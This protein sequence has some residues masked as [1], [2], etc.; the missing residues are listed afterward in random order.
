MA[1]EKIEV[2]ISFAGSEKAARQMEALAGNTEDFSRSLANLS[3]EEV[4]AADKMARAE[5]QAKRL[6]SQVTNNT[7]GLQ[8]LVLAL[9]AQ[10]AEADRAATAEANLAREM[11]ILSERADI[12]VQ[13]FERQELGMH[14]VEAA[15]TSMA[16]KLGAATA[17]LGGMIS[18][19]GAGNPEMARLGGLMSVVGSAASQFQG[20]IDPLSAGIAALTVVVSAIAVAM[21]H[22]SERERALMETNN[23][24]S[25]SYSELHDEMA[26]ALQA[27]S[28]LERDMQ[29]LGTE[30]QA[31]ARVARLESLQ[32]TTV[33]ELDRLTSR[34]EEMNGLERTFGGAELERLDRDIAR[35]QNTLANLRVGI[36]GARAGIQA[37]RDTQA[38]EALDAVDPAMEEAPARRRGGGGRAAEDRNQAEIDRINRLNAAEE[39]RLAFIRQREEEEKAGLEEIIRLERQRA[40]EELQNM[41]AAKAAREAYEAE[42]AQRRQAQREAEAGAIRKLAAEEEARIARMRAQIDDQ[43]K[44]IAGVFST[45]FGLAIRGQE[46]LQSTA[47][48]LLRAAHEEGGRGRLRWLGRSLQSRWPRLREPPGRRCQS[49]GGCRAH[50][51][52]RIRGRDRCCDCPVYSRRRA[53]P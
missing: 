40:A 22:L 37:A 28:E 18:V 41:E 42:A 11:T 7:R 43:G 31:R 51:L 26:S 52:G 21:D 38:L 20:K 27:Q 47:S 39:Q 9:R 13:S 5:A 8:Q 12:A 29:G 34:R 30:T 23:A 2:E 36:E 16:S 15:S 1:D 14:A 53:T 50:R 45:A 35:E 44:E 49:R 48:G 25:R 33:A 32:A 10:R 24:L 46:D 17:S 4:A 3:R 6:E 19:V